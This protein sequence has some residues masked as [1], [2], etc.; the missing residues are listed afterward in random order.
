MQAELR[1][2]SDSSPVHVDRMA[3][4]LLDIRNPQ[5]RSQVLS[6]LV[7]EEER[8]GLELVQQLLNTVRKTFE[9]AQENVSIEN[10]LWRS[11]V[12]KLYRLAAFYQELGREEEDMDTAGPG[13]SSS[14]VEELSLSL[15]TD[16]EEVT[17]LLQ[18]API[19]PAAPPHTAL[20]LHDFLSCFETEGDLGHWKSSEG[21]SVRLRKHLAPLLSLSLHRALTTLVSSR[22][23]TAQDHFL[24]LGLAPEQ[25][26]QLAVT[27]SLHTMDNSLPG[28]QALHAT[29]AFLLNFNANVD[30]RHRANCQDVVRSGL[31][32][33]PMSATVFALATVWRCVLAGQGNL[34]LGVWAEEWSRRLGQVRAFLSLQELLLELVP[35]QEEPCHSLASV[36]E[37]GDGRVAELVARWLYQGLDT[38]ARGL[39]SALD[40]QEEEQPAVRLVA[41]AREHFPSSCS[42]TLLLLHLAWEQVQAWSRDRDAT[43]LLSSLLPGLCALPCPALRARLLSLLWRTFFQKLLQDAARLTET[44]ARSPG[45]SGRRAASCEELLQLRSCSVAPVLRAMAELLDLQLQSLALAG[46]GEGGVVQYDC[47]GAEVRPHLLEH[48]QAAAEADPS[49]VSLQHQLAVVL[50]LSWNLGVTVRPLHIFSTTET[51]QLLNTRP[52]VFSSLFVDHNVAVGK[53]RVAWVG[54]VVEAA[55]GRVHVRPGE[56][57]QYD[58]AEFQEICL[59]LQQLAR[60]WFLSDLVKMCQVTCIIQNL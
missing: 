29:M 30:D 8:L 6:D 11:K 46:E 53:T 33:A 3:E 37:A 5:L 31:R 48:V 58:T 45:S 25:F 26:L 50:E 17:T 15:A 59:K 51:Q 41:R 24:L 9:D 32:R 34:T 35:G 56:A 12:H 36:F 20:A 38:T 28:L 10:K 43:S 55:V 39:A 13:T 57:R 47:L 2:L 4:L 60:L 16:L 1:D 44:L 18:V 19:A 42:R 7:A 23:A 52:G 40:T 22:L 54:D 21:L 27:S 49:L 14:S